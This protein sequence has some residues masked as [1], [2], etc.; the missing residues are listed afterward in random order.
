MPVVIEAKKRE[1][2]GK[3][4]AKNYRD[5]GSIPGVYYFHGNEA[6]PLLFDGMKLTKFL[7]GHRGLIDLQIQG[8]KEPLKCFLKDFQRDPVTDAPIHVDFQGVKMGEKIVIYVPLVVKGTPVGVKAG[9]ILE[10]ITRELEIECFP[11]DLPELLEVDVTQLEIGDSIHIEDLKYENITILDDPEE[12]VVL[13]EAPRI[14][15]EEEVSEEEEE[16]AEPELIGEEKEDEEGEEGEER[17]KK[18][19]KE[20]K[21]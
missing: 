21:E 12:T 1:L 10:H 3:K 9:G 4:N 14:V 5:E 2:M 6:I 11:K 20:E 15:V 7:M 8:E 13:V 19:R 16:M 17:E 18:E